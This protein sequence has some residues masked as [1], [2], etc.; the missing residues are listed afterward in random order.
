MRLKAGYIRYLFFLFA[1]LV[2]IPIPFPMLSGGLLWI[3]PFMFFNSVLAVKDLVLLNL[4]G[5]LALIIIFFQYRWI[6]RYACPLGVVCDWASKAGKVKDIIRFDLSKYL[7][8]I[9]LIMAIF[10]APVLILL[11]PFNIFHM[12]FEGLRTGFGIAAFLKFLLLLSVIIINVIHPNIWCRSIC[13]LGGLQLLAYNTRKIFKKTPGAKKSIFNRRNFLISGVSGLTA[14]FILPSLSVFSC[15]STIRPP[16]SLQE[17]DIN[18]ICARCGNCSNV[19]PT[20]IIKQSDDFSRIGSLLTPVIDFSESYCLPDCTL[21]GD[22]CPSGAI[23]KF[24]KDEKKRL[25]MAS[26]HINVNDCWLQNQRDCDLC[27]FHCAFEAIEIKKT[28]NST[29]ALPVLSEN[30]CVGC[31]ACKIVCPADAINVKYHP[32]T[33]QISSRSTYNL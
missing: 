21:C 10:G 16:A 8:I 17:P 28:G 20:N 32:H 18:L 19:C 9:A 23:S 33:S 3:S 12:S 14:G 13:P 22:V 1:I 2:A 7:A 30:K 29:L 26:V 27:R 5:L 4:L 11:D 6:C 24:T 31:A 25:F 15:D